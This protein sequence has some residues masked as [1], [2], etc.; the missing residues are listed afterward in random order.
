MNKNITSC[1]KILFRLLVVVSIVLSTFNSGKISAN[2]MSRTVAQKNVNSNQSETVLEKEKNGEYESVY[3]TQ[4]K[5]ADG[6]VE[7]EV[8]LNPKNCRD[9][10]IQ[11]DN[12]K[13]PVNSKLAETIGYAHVEAKVRDLTGDKKEEIVLII[14]GGSSGSIQAV[15]VFENTE[16][17]WKEIRL[18]ANLYSDVPKFL[19]NQLKKMGIKM[20][21][22]QYYYRTVSLKKE[23]LIFNY[24]IYKTGEQKP[25]VTIRRKVLYSPS[26]EKFIGSD[27][28]LIQVKKKV[29][30]C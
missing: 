15:Q 12:E 27:T 4:L 11:I 16:R 8:F 25:I 28:T 18:P 29:G 23:K 26:K 9:G 19:R 1:S 3:S 2:E 20:D 10:I 13:I 30:K 5:V 14:S 7:I 24:I 6:Q 22:V 17:G 21:E